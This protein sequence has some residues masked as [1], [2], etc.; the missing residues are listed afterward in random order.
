MSIPLTWKAFEALHNTEYKENGNGR[1]FNE[2]QLEYRDKLISQGFKIPES[3]KSGNKIKDYLDKINSL[4]NRTDR[5]NE[6]LEELKILK[7][8][9]NNI[10][11]RL[12]DELVEVGLMFGYKYKSLSF[13]WASIVNKKKKKESK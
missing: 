6:L 10:T 9:H 11:T 13:N 5:Q 7:N 2:H 8:V 1:D 4:S 3:G 12:H